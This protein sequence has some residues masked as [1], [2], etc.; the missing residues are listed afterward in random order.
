MKHLG[1]IVLLTCELYPRK[2]IL[3]VFKI[4]KKLKEKKGTEESE[5][6]REES[7]RKREW[8]RDSN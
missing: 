5:R 2:N 6:E 1:A 8:E 3:T 7:E 4:E